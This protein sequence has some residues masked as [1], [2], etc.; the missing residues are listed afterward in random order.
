MEY[1]MSL[2]LTMVRNWQ[3]MSL[4]DLLKDGNLD[5]RHHL[6]IIINQMEKQRPQ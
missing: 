5:M 2:Y 6:R 3:A 4:E 1:Q